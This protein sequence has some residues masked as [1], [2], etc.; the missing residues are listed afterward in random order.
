MN[1]YELMASNVPVWCKEM[2]EYNKWT[3]E[4]VLAQV[5]VPVLLLK[6]SRTARWWA[7]SVAYME[8]NLADSRVVEVAGAGHMGPALAPEGIAQEIVRFFSL[9]QA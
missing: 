2:P 4:S 3:A 9:V 8:G 7:D 6:G 1:T 5:N